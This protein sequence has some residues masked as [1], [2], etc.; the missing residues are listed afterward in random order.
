[1]ALTG[2]SQAMYSEPLWP[3]AEQAL[4]DAQGGDGAGLLEL[5][6]EYFRRRDDGTW[7]NLLEAFQVITCQDDPTR[8]TVAQDDATAPQFRAVAP[9]SSPATIG[10]YFCTFFPPSTDPEVEVNTKGAGPIV[11]V[12]TTG[13]PATPLATSRKMADALDD[14]RLLV[15]HAEGHTGYAPGACSG[16][17]VDQYL[18]D[19]VGKT[20]ADGTECT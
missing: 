10:S 1:M 7:P 11:V 16:D 19:P 17:V 3:Q 13:D 20:P 18:I 14:G 6:D 5:F 8:L 4:A 2:V 15:V 12:G 9:R